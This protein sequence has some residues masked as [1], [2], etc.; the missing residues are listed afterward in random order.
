MAR[1]AGPIV[2]DRGVFAKI[3]SIG[4]FE[5]AGKIPE[6]QDDDE[7]EDDVPNPDE[8]DLIPTDFLRKNLQT[9]LHLMRL[10]DEALFPV[11]GYT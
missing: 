7:Y 5:N 11:V 10:S 9:N 6:D 2:A 4:S 8:Q 1:L 3:N